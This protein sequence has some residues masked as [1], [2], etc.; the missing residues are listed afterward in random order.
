VA[1]GVATMVALRAYH[2][3]AAAAAGAE[4]DLLRQVADASRLLADRL[5]DGRRNE[6]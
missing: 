2:R 4:A 5:A 6:P 3:S 1:I